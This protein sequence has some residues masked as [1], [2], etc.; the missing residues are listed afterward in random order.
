LGHPGVHLFGAAYLNMFTATPIF[1]IIMNVVLHFML[2][3]F[4]RESYVGIL[5]KK[6]DKK[7]GLKV[8]KMEKTKNIH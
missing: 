7:A 2:Q 1:A 4:F 6:K 3:M 5:E 8:E